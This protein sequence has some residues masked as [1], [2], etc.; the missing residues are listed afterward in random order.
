M[1]SMNQ[2]VVGIVIKD[3]AILLVHRLKNNKEYY[4][5]PGGGVEENESLESALIREIKEELSLDVTKSRLLFQLSN[6]LREQ[7]GGHVI[8]Y[9]NEH[10][11]LIE[12]CSGTPELGG[13]EKDRMNDT[14][15]YFLEWI[16][17]DHL[18]DMANLYPQEA[19]QQLLMLMQTEILTSEL[20]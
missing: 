3:D 1:E 18:K 20:S 19:V 4:V 8:G 5:F 14:N 13:P 10:Y 7:Y 15:Q 9:P 17:I 6:Q 12:H 2:R 16:A 11:F